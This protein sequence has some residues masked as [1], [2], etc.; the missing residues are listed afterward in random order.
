MKKQF[1]KPEIMTAKLSSAE[2][3][4]TSMLRDKGTNGLISVKMTDVERAE[5]ERQNYWA[6]K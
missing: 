1:I 5:S 2:A 4:M 6:G 3:V